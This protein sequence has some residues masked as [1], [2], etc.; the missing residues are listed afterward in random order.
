MKAP[1]I[2]VY[3]PG[4]LTWPGDAHNWDGRAVTWTLTRCWPE[5]AAEKV[6]YFCGPIGR[7][8]GQKARAEKLYR[9][10]MR[11]RNGGW[12]I[13]LVGHSNGCDVILTMLRDFPFWTSVGRVHLVCGAAEASFERNHLNAWLTCGRVQEVIVY[14]AGLDRALALAHTLPGTL[15]GYGTLG[16]HGARDVAPE[17]AGR[18]KEKVWLTYGHS[19]CW[20]DAVF[21]LTMQN[22]TGSDASDGSD[23]SDEPQAN[24]RA[25]V[26][27]DRN[28]PSRTGQR[29]PGEGGAP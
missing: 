4:I 2:N 3:V 25:D 15:L 21:D 16:L 10:L 24:R 12:R 1:C 19:D 9:T 23:W 27:A 14:R 5:L 11:Y 8:F 13:N 7:A 28:G 6:E 29:A 26:A 17:V 20:S 18:V 22:F